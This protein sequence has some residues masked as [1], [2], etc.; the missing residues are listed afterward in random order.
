MDHHKQ[1]E[2]S[3]PGCYRATQLSDHVGAIQGTEAWPIG[4]ALKCVSNNQV[5]LVT[6]RSGPPLLIAKP[7]QY[8][9]CRGAK[10]RIGNSDVINRASFFL[11]SLLSQPE[12]HGPGPTPPPQFNDSPLPPT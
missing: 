5:H 11:I 1:S 10:Q 7:Q 4:A 6:A 12:K 2:C 8:S 9:H 3:S